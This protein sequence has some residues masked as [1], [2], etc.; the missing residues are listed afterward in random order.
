MEDGASAEIAVVGKEGLVGIFLLLAAALP[1]SRAESPRVL[2][3]LKSLRG[4][5]H[6][7]V[8]QVLTR[9]A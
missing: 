2:R 6:E 1:P 7:E 9:G 3:R 5:S 8:E 4:L